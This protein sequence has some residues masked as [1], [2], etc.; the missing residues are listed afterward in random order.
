VSKN[1]GKNP[2]D[3]SVIIPY[4]NHKVLLQLRSNNK[5]IFYPLYWGCIGGAKEFR[6][7]PKRTAIREFYEETNIKLNKK[8]I[9]F[10]SR[11][12]FFIKPR[13]KKIV[14]YFYVYKIRKIK[15]FI[16]K[17][18]VHEGKKLKFFSSKNFNKI[19]KV[20]PYDKFILDYFYKIKNY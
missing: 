8:D 11:L 7:S 14:R 20:V 19:K 1:I 4:H 3:A 9:V 12:I 5:K 2:K 10:F 18:K 6:E 16:K 17:M 13:K 15:N